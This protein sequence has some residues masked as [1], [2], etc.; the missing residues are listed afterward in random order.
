MNS[1]QIVR[2]YDLGG[3]ITARLRD[4]TRHYFGGYYHVR[5]E[6]SAD[7]PLSASPFAGPEEYQAARRLLGER[8]RFRRVLEKMAVPETDIATARQSLL[9][10]FDA[11]V[12]PYLSRPDFP[13]RFMRSEYAKCLKSSARR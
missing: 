9:E 10:A 1:E 11:N 6:V 4:E 12:L 2:E 7:I 13:E 8:I 3:G 5:I